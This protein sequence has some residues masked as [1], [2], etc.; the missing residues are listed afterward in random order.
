[1]NANT[2][3]L[4]EALALLGISH[5]ASMTSGKRDWFDADGVHIGTHDAHEGWERLRRMAGAVAAECGEAA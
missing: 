1:M 5:R 2:K 3:T 4:T